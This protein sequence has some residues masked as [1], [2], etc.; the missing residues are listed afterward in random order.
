V[1]RALTVPA[2]QDASIPSPR[3][4]MSLQHLEVARILDMVNL[5]IAVE[6]LNFSVFDDRG[7]TDHVPDLPGVFLVVAPSLGTHPATLIAERLVKLANDKVVGFAGGI[8]TDVPNIGGPKGVRSLG[9]RRSETHPPPRTIPRSDLGG[10]E[11]QIAP[12]KNTCSSPKRSIVVLFIANPD[13]ANGAV[14]PNVKTIVDLMIKV[15]LT[16]PRL[17]LAENFRVLGLPSVL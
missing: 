13:L 5:L 8:S 6:D 17:E 15:A 14:R 1:L 2:P 3:F 16:V 4:G 12:H 9:V 7:V 11:D 10:R